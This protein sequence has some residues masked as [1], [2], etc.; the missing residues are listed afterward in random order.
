[1]DNKKN[2]VVGECYLFD[3][4]NTERQLENG[5]N[6][7]IVSDIVKRLFHSPLIHVHPV[8]KFGQIAYGKTYV[9]KGELLTPMS[10][11]K[12][13]NVVIRYPSSIPTFSMDDTALLTNIAMKVMARH[14]DGSDVL[15]EDDI[16]R[17]GSLVQKVK[18]YAEIAERYRGED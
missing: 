16:I 5:V 14:S 10:N 6:V 4:D 8:N 7:V 9:V 3:K 17:L 12:S 18:F 11:D 1:M 2:I 15:H 13:D